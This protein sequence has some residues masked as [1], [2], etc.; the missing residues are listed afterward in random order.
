MK[1]PAC[2]AE[3]SMTIFALAFT[4]AEKGNVI[5]GKRHVQVNCPHI[6]MIPSLV[7]EMLTYLLTYLLH[8]AESFLSS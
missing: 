7:T 6:Y 1:T 8:G 4:V 5:I 3:R 2:V